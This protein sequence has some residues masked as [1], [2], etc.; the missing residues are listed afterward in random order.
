MRKV[1]TALAMVVAGAAGAQDAVV[2]GDGPNLHIEVGG[3]VEGTI[4]IDLLPEIAPQHV[5]RVITLAETGAYNDVA[6]HR[7]IE[8]FMA[9]TGDVQFGK[10]GADARRAGTGGSEL[11][12]LPAEFS[13][14]TFAPGVLGM[15]RAQ[16]PNSAN[17]Q[18]FITTADAS[19]LD[20]QYTVLGRV[21]EGMDVVNG[22]KLG[23]GQSG[24]V[25]DP[26]YMLR[27]TVSGQ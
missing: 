11:P 3:S 16:N 10:R 27:V 22:I 7:V 23:A 8:G 13:S 2:D 19:F 25:Q 1:L 26:D 9:Q 15:A 20:G 21:I 6:F 5:E 14:E 24:A 17:S 18:F 4:I 12:D